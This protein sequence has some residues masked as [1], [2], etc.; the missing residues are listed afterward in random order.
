MNERRVR[1]LLG[2]WIQRDGTIRGFRQFVCYPEY[3]GGCKVALDGV[4]SADQVEA[5]AWWMR[6]GRPN[7]SR[8]AGRNVGHRFE[9]PAAASPPSRSSSGS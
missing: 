5:L 6:H 3:D 4:F 2:D 8:T 1:A 9:L 7:T